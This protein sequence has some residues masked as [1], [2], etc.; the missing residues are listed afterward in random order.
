MSSWKDNSHVVTAAISA[1]TTLLFAIAVY[2]QSL[3]PTRTSALNNEINEKNKESEEKSETI[4]NQKKQILEA[5]QKNSSLTEELKNLNNLLAEALN[6][7]VMK[8]NNPYPK[9]LG[10]LRIK[11]SAD[12]AFNIFRKD[13]IDTSHLGYYSVKLDG[14][15]SGVTYYFDEEEETKKITHILVHAQP[16]IDLKNFKAQDFNVDRLQPI[17]EEA[18]GQ[19]LKLPMEGYYIWDL[20]DAHIFKDDSQS[21][22]IMQ[23][24]FVPGTWPKKLIKFVNNLNYCPSPT[25]SSLSESN[26][27]S[28]PL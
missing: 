16:K 12:L 26:N 25:T 10:K 22:L 14:F 27:Q 8:H 1:A 19:P 23:K 21:Y 4:S 7:D 13:Q 11:D 15:I 2:E 18:F 5:E 3:I 17:L 20:A 28:K 6:T 9:G 24:G